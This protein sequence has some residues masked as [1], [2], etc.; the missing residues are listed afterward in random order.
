VK[1]ASAYTLYWSTAAGVTTASGTKVALGA[2]TQATVTDLTAGTT[3]YFI[4]TATKAGVE[5]GPSATVSVTPPSAPTNLTA[6]RAGSN[7]S[8]SWTAVNGA[9]SYTLYWSTT[10]GKALQGTAVGSISGSA[11]TFIPP[12]AGLT[13]YF[14]VT[15]TTGASES[16]PSAEQG[17]VTLPAAPTGLGATLVAQ[18]IQVTWDTMPEATSYNIY[19][20]TTSGVTS[21]SPNKLTNVTSNPQSISGF[22]PATTLYLVVTAENAAGEGPISSEASVD[23]AGLCVQ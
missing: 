15:A 4:V 18:A 1:G 6:T 3:Y 14:V 23:V 9:S 7:V 5:S 21:A 22:C 20:D 12:T 2:V 8:L 10:A 16:G 17:V 19:W 13:Y 11:Y